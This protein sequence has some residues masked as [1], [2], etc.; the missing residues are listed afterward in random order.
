MLTSVIGVFLIARPEVVF[1]E[2]EEDGHFTPQQRLIGLII[3][4]ASCVTSAYMYIPIR[5]LQKTSTASQ[6]A[7]YS[8]FSIVLGSLSLNVYSMSTNSLIETPK[9]THDWNMIILNCIV[10]VVGQGTFALALKI[11]EAGLISIMRTFTIVVAFALQAI[12]L[13][14]HTI[15]MTSVI[16]AVIICSGCI[17]VSGKKYLD[18]KKQKQ[19]FN[20]D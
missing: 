13:P 7:F 20:S 2:Q 19:A 15:Y 3:S 10:G 14:H 1:G 12:F 17:V 5:K 8:L 6:V 4:I 16:G 11:E 18:A 9:E